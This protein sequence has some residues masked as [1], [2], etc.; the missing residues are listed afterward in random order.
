[1]SY[2]WTCHAYAAEN[3]KSVSQCQACG[4]AAFAS[5]A[6]IGKHATGQRKTDLQVSRE[7]AMTVLFWALIA[8]FVLYFKL[9][10]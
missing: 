3:S 2:D 4:C 5:M 10:A 1:M 8:G 6:E 7:V 9:L